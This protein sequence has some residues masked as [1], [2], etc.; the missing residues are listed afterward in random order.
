MVN[1]AFFLKVVI[2]I[3]ILPLFLR[4]PLPSLKISFII[5]K[6]ALSRVR[7]SFNVILL[8]LKDMVDGLLEGI[9]L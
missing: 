2:Y 3:P 9:C 8:H 4:V 1:V 6:T 5:Q 7:Y